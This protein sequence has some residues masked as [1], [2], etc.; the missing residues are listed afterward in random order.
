MSHEN[1]CKVVRK[2]FNLLI[3]R[4]L[5]LLALAL[6]LLLLLLLAIAIATAADADDADADAVVDAADAAA[7]N[8]YV[9]WSAP[10]GKLPPT[11]GWPFV[12]APTRAP[13]PELCCS[14]GGD[15]ELR[16]CSCC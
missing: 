1:W 8:V 7:A 15:G 6:V 16:C 2:R 13:G 12:V 14:C 10:D 11:A 5:E 3:W 9:N 4:T